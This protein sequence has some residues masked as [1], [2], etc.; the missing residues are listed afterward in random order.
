[1]GIIKKHIQEQN[2]FKMDTFK[3]TMIAE[4]DF[5]MAGVDCPT[6]ELIIEAY[7]FLVN[8]GIVWELQGSFG[9][10]ASDLIEQGL[11]MLKC[12]TCEEYRYIKNKGCTDTICVEHNI[13]EK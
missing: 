1:M 13:N 8:T 2:N 9:R 4:G 12:P 11:I 10:T 6:E 5:T 7:Q 3:A